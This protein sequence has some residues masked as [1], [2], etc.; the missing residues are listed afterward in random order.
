[1]TDKTDAIP[2]AA[3]SWQEFFAS[4]APN[5]QRVVD[6]FSY[7]GTTGG[8]ERFKAE[9]PVITL[10]CAVCKGDRLFDSTSDVEAT[11]KYARHVFVYLKCRNCGKHYKVF[12]V[13]LGTKKGEKS[14]MALELG[15]LPQYGIDLPDTIKSLLSNIDLDLFRKGLVAESNG[16]GIGAFSYYRRV[17][18]NQRVKIIDRIISA[19]KALGEDEVLINELNAAKNE[20]QF[21]K[22][23]E[24]I[25]HAL[26][27]FLF[28]EGHNP[29]T[30]LYDAVSNGVH[31]EA[32]QECMESAQTIRK[33][34]THLLIKLDEALA[35]DDEV[36]GAVTRLLKAKAARAKPPNPK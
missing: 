3:I 28:I 20:R 16:L 32:D 22:A 14:F 29:L 25:K 9:I 26:P 4:V 27:K 11:T 1:M 19:A 24:S 21:T 12:A 13:Q 10:R 2:V 31:A 8:E 34:L 6:G 35:S 5:E 23:V 18:D 36:K 33:L 7:R 30:L 17:L 15:E